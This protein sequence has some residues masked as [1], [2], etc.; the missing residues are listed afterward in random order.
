MI[1]G[2]H[3]RARVESIQSILV[4]LDRGAAS[5]QALSKAIALARR[6][7]AALELFL[8]DADRAYVLQ[9]A[10]DARAA[11]DVRSG[12]A[13]D[14]R[15]Y[16][17]ELRAGLAIDDL[18]VT[19]DAACESPLCEG[20]VHKVRRAA[21]DLV[22][23]TIGLDGSRPGAVLT[24]TDFE[25]VRTC[26]APLLLTRGTTWSAAPAFAAAIDLSGEERTGLTHTVLRTASQLATRCGASLDLI[27]GADREAGAT[28]SEQL[29]RD[30]LATR[31][32]E[33]RAEA[34]SLHI[35]PGDPARA[36]PD[37]AAQRRYDLIVLGALTHRKALTQ[38]VGT[39]TGR[40]IER[41]DCDFLVVK[42][43][44]ER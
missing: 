7:G 26:P 43:Q 39:L 30:T 38:L 10:Y 5:R 1:D 20:I 17:E 33:V 27:F 3:R 18:R 35:V 41:V 15:K 24:A 16:L 28:Q 29:L 4:A 11:Q 6:L 8:C 9:H 36:L 44:G 32:A 2:T 31:A 12:F 40:L 37:F 14:A 23:R 13:D 22:V 34:R 19:L 42:A 25:L 21:P